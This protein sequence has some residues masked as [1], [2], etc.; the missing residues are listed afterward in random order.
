[1]GR[2]RVHFARTATYAELTASKTPSIVSNPKSV[3]TGTKRDLCV[4]AGPA[5]KWLRDGLARAA[6]ANEAL[7]MVETIFVTNGVITDWVGCTPQGVLKRRP[8]P[9]PKNAWPALFRALG[10]NRDPEQRNATR[11]RKASSRE[12]PV[13]LLWCDDGSGALKRYGLTIQELELLCCFEHCRANGVANLGSWAVDS[14]R[15]VSARSIIVAVQRYEPPPT[16]CKG[17]GVFVQTYER[18]RPR[19]TLTSVELRTGAQTYD[20]CPEAVLP[21]Q[22]LDEKDEQAARMPWGA[23]PK[24]HLEQESLRREVEPVRVGSVGSGAAAELRGAGL[25]VPVGGEFRRRLG[26]A[27]DAVVKVL[28][29]HTRRRV[30]AI[31]CDFLFGADD[32]VYLLCCRG[33]SLLAVKATH[34]QPPA[35]TSS[36][37]GRLLPIPFREEAPEPEPEPEVVAEKVPVWHP[38]AGQD[39][40]HNRANADFEDQQFVAWLC[41][42]NAPPK[43]VPPPKKSAYA[44]SK[45]VGIL[46]RRLTA[47]RTSLEAA[48]QAARVAEER[49][50]AEARELAGPPSEAVVAAR[51]MAST[52]ETLEKKLTDR[53]ARSLKGEK[54]CRLSY[55]QMRRRVKQALREPKV[56]PAGG[57]APAPA[58]PEA[59][60][61]PGKLL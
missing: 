58:V 5:S 59:A 30:T 16:R 1:M 35:A 31:T 41:E 20:P 11:P 46:S 57:P 32:E 47:S 24:E 4:D 40:I 39:S 29:R 45:L 43:Y 56:K 17:S 53:L 15:A 9:Q 8:T 14:V 44:Q 6:D 54:V 22:I 3:L 55:G 36:A 51:E 49:V 28:Q 12:K 13:A 25:A 19:P 23:P 33:V 21:G 10:P 2:G 26:D 61:V 7:R 50:L 27:V 37:T 34:L 48:K 18:G 42:V 60:P 38:P 52:V